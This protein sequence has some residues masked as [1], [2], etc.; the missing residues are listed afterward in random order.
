VATAR[1]ASAPTVTSAP[2]GARVGR[3]RR[4]SV[5]GSPDMLHTSALWM[6]V[7]LELLALVALRRYFKRHHGG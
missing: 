5:L 3:S 7:G 6:L 2:G 4:P 1:T